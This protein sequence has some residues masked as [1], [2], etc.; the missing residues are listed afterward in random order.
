MI[1]DV[2]DNRQGDFVAYPPLS[3]SLLRQAPS[4][5]SGQVRINPTRGERDKFR[6]GDFVAM[7]Q[8]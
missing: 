3:G 5:T 1:K 6:I 7:L 2:E 4:N 8:K